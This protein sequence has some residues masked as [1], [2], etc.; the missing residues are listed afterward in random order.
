MNT[1]GTLSFES[2]ATMIPVHPTLFVTVSEIVPEADTV[3][4]AAR[5]I[6]AEEMNIVLKTIFP[7]L[8]PAYF[9]VALLSP[10][11]EIS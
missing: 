5:P 2:Q 4:A 7:T 9:A 10:T 8:I 3:S 6:I 1:A 11:T